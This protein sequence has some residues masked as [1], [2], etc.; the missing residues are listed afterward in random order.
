[1]TVAYKTSKNIIFCFVVIAVAKSREQGA[2]TSIYCAVD[3][4]LN[5]KQAFFYSDC[6]RKDSN[7][8]SRYIL[9]LYYDVYRMC[10]IR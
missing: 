6:A 5:C 2:A 7:D 1:M 9:D 10:I 4:S 8:D 3:P